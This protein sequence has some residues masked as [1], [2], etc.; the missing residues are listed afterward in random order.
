MTVLEPVAETQVVKQNR[1]REIAISALIGVL[2][3]LLLQ[4]TPDVPGGFDG[5]RHVKQAWRILAEPRAMFSD[6]WRVAYFWP[7]PVDAWFGYEALLAPFT[8]ILPLIAALKLFSAIIFGGI[9]Y[10]LFQ[11][12]RFLNIEHRIGW[13][14]VI[15]TGS[16]VTL[17]RATTVR[18]F[19]LSVLLTLVAALLTLKD[20]PVK[21][22]LVSA[23]HAV[24]YSM[25]FLAGLAPA[26]WLLVRRDRASLKLAL[27]SGAGICLG[28]LVNPYFP[29]NL[30]FD[31]LQAKVVKI[32]LDAHVRM[33]GE[34]YP[35]NSWWWLPASLIIATLWVSA[36]IFRRKSS[37]ASN[38]FFLLSIATF[39]GSLRVGRTADF[40]VPFAMLFA[41]TVLNPYAVKLRGDLKYVGAL[42]A[43]ICGVNVFLTFQ[44]GR[45]SP[46]LDRFRG[47]AEFLKRE[48]PGELVANAQWGDYQYL[49][50]LNSQ[51]RYMIGIEPTFMY[52][53]SARK[54]WLWQHMSDDEPSTCGREFCAD[55]ERTDI[56]RAVRDEL[57]AR[58]ILAEHIVNPRLE[59][60]L[61]QHE[62]VQ[63][64]FR[65]ASFSIFELAK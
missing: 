60:L 32:G 12:L 40:F 24:S 1:T 62:G 23:L 21:L 18:P 6:P 49:F 7:K 19:L 30:L 34:L 63:E 16:S 22:L 10:V 33:G 13:V 25:F 48:A 35:V 52:M 28:L 58:Y 44:Y 61:R 20:K 42:F 46:S 4:A 39:L 47:A 41:A 37:A 26:M 15:L 14:V 65:D 53:N 3:F 51:N 38:L 31:F 64:V 59:A 27:A 17:C 8:A 9:A 54:Y 5:Y 29:Q 43:L 55:A 2:F 11:L 36:L 45:T 50:F 56:S 57:G